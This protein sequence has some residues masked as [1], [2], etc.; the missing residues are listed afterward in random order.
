MAE[1]KR[2]TFKKPVFRLSERK[3]RFVVKSLGAVVVV[4]TIL[5]F[6]SFVSYLFTWKG[7]FSTVY[8][9]TVMKKSEA[10]ANWGGSIG[11]YWAH[12]M[13]GRWFGVAAL[14][15]LVPLCAASLK[16][17]RKDNID[18]ALLRRISDALNHDFFHDLSDDFQHE[19][20]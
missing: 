18:I 14:C 17:F 9:P 3:K 15:V 5:T 6:L 20:P 16:I 11:F 12:L 7:D 19:L 10:I 13:V 4:V 2:A 1:K 8:D